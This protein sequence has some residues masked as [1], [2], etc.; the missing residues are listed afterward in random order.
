M[1]LTIKIQNFQQKKWYFIDSDSRGNYSYK[2]K[3]KFLTNSL[4]S[5]L[6]DYFDAYILVTWNIIVRRRNS[7][8]T[9][10]IALNAA[11]QVVFKNCAQFKDC[12]TEI[13][14]T[15]VDYADFVNITM[16][17]YNLIEYSDN[18]SDTSGSLWDFKRDEIV[19][20]ANVTN[21]DNAPSFKYKA[22]IIGNTK[23]NGVME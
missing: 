4:E 15:F 8:N 12:R 13:N 3:I 16:T 1:V 11:T 5:S 22:S 23:D 10:D 20:N 6:S 19:D 21:D 9:E 7:A 2:N 17:M 14:D 18:Y